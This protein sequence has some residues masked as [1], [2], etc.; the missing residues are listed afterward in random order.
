MVISKEHCRVEKEYL[1][2]NTNRNMRRINGVIPP[3][4]LSYPSHG[5]IIDYTPS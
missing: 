2:T 5:I 3:I 4:F 1:G